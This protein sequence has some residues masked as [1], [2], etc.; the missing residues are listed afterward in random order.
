MFDMGAPAME[1]FFIPCLS[2]NSKFS[3]VK[4][5]TDSFNEQNQ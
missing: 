1:P 3:P 2:G 4:T 5:Q